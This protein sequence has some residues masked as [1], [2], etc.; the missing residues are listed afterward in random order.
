MPLCLPLPL[1][2]KLSNRRDLVFLWL[3]PTTMPIIFLHIVVWKWVNN[4]VMTRSAEVSWPWHIGAV[5]DIPDIGRSNQQAKGEPLNQT[6]AVRFI[7]SLPPRGQ[8]VEKTL[9]KWTS[10][11]IQ[12]VLIANGLQALWICTIFAFLPK[13]GTNYWPSAFGKSVSQL[14]EKVS[15]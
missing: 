10:P 6:N 9:Q 1:E 8:T 12:E 5:F 3:M 11:E 15:N 7:Y 2:Q 4:W 14:E 13:A